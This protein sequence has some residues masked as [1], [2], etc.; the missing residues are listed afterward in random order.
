VEHLNCIDGRWVPARSGETFT[1]VNP[2]RHSDVIGAWP[3]S[4]A[5]DVRDAIDAATR[6]L[7]AWRAVPGPERGRL[8]FRFHAI[9]DSR[10]EEL[11]RALTREEGKTLQESRG[12]VQKSLNIV[13]YVA[14][15]GR[16]IPGET[17][18]SDMPSTF[19]YTVRQPLGVVAVITPWNF[20]V[21]IPC[22]KIAP[23]LVAGNTVVF[24]P[25]SLTPLT[26]TLLV[27]MLHE[28]G[29]PPGVVQLVTGSG[30]ALGGALLGDARV[31][32]VSFTGSNEIG[33][34]IARLAAAGLKKVQ[35]EMGGKNPVLVLED[36]DLDLAAEGCVQGAFGSSGQR[37]TATSRA[38][39]VDAVHDAFV[40]R[41]L[42][43]M[44]RLRVGDG[45]DPNTDIG[46]L[47]DRSQL[48]KVTGHIDS[49]QA[50]GAVLRAGGRRLRGG[51]WDGGWFVEPTLFTGV[52]PDMR[53][54]R[55]EIFG[56]VLCVLRVRD[57]DQG[58]DV[59]NDVEYGLSSSIYSRDVERVFRFIDRIETGITHV[60]SPTVG[61]EAQLPFGGIK[62]TGVGSREMGR[63]AIEFFTE[64]K[65]VY[66]D[67]TGRKRDS[68]IY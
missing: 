58:L 40:D 55:E 49:A 1:V 42:D 25:A 45:A 19:A 53:V 23:A 8:L 67:Y 5:A 64:I 13:E 65:T 36:A 17:V 24:K 28:A 39:V 21:A 46:P 62:A 16:R 33:S 61:G 4:S 22:W 44:R 2:A 54:A 47:V 63:T 12:E 52:R 32:G 66:V 14:G 57:L 20:P 7:P 18:P 29:I 6:A 3:S 41:V 34:E 31:R 68:L 48:D 60:N 27:E 50:E 56:P 35:L 15:E 11:A 37:C 38:I 10:R 43:R 9:L 59:A 26:A 51:A 30:G